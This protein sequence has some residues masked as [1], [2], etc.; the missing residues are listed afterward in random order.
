LFKD[1]NF[2]ICGDT[3][4]FVFAISSRVSDR[5]GF[6]RFDAYLEH[7]TIN[8][9]HSFYFSENHRIA[10]AKAMFFVLMQKNQPLFIPRDSSYMSRE[11][12]LSIGVKNCMFSSKVHESESIESKVSSIDEADILAS[13]GVVNSS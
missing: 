7:L 8:F 12:F 3:S 4:L 11:A 9:L 2:Y 13:A 6:R 1:R 5:K 10:I